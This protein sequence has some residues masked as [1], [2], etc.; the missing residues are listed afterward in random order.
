MFTGVVTTANRYVGNQFA[1]KD[2]LIIDTRKL[3]GNLNPYQRVIAAGPMCGGVKPG[4]IVRIN[5]SRYT[6]AK[7]VPGKIEDKLGGGRVQ[8]DEY[9]ADVEVPYIEINGQN[10]LY[11]QNND[12]EYIVTKYE[13]DEGGLLE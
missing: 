6:V 2:G 7:H 13:V 4:D 12:L 11:L 1:D 5:F 9:S 8:H 10:C 3:A